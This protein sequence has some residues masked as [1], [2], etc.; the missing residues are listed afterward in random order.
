MKRWTNR[1]NSKIGLV[2][3]GLLLATFMG[4][5]HAAGPAA[6]NSNSAYACTNSKGSSVRMRSGPG[7]N[8]RIKGGIP[9]GTP[10]RI[11][12]S[13]DGTDGRTWYL[14]KWRGM[15]GWSRYDYVCGV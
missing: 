4:N 12:E 3:A 10:V 6:Y 1:A 14:V 15:S 7:Q 5:S 2:T 8:F 13:T 9:N 11:I